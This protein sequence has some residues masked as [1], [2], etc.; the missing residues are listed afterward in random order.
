MNKDIK[1]IIENMSAPM[2]SQLLLKTPKGLFRKNT[3]SRY[4]YDPKTI[5]GL[6]KL[7]TNLLKNKIGAIY[8]LKKKDNR[9]VDVSTR[10]FYDSKTKKIYVN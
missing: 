7:M 9:I 1:Y 8:H 3:P 6:K 4:F 10:S 2:R 5:K